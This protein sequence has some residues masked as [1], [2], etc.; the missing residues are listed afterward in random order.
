[1]AEARRFAVGD[2][3]VERRGQRRR[4]IRRTSAT[5]SASRSTGGAVAAAAAAAASL[6]DAVRG[7]LVGAAASGASPP[8]RSHVRRPRPPRSG[9]SA[10]RWS[11]ARRPAALARRRCRA[12]AGPRRPAP[13]RRLGAPRRR[14]VVVAAPVGDDEPADHEHGCRGSGRQCLHPAGAAPAAAIEGTTFGG[15]GGHRLR[16]SSSKADRAAAIA[17]SR[18]RRWRRRDRGDSVA[19]PAQP[20]DFGEQRRVALDAGA[21]VRRWPRRR[22]RRSP[23]QRRRGSSWSAIIGRF[24]RGSGTWTLVG[25]ATV[26]EAAGEQR[27]AAGDPRLHGADRDVEGGGDLGVVEIAQ[28]AQHD[29]DAELLGQLVERLVDRQPVDDGFD[30][31][32]RQGIGDVAAVP[33]SSARRAVPAAARACAVRR[34]RRWW[35][36]GRSTSRTPA[37]PSKRASPR[38]IEIIAS[39]AASSASRARAGDAPAD[40]VHTV[41]VAS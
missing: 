35:R 3:V 34:G 31:P 26:P 9:W 40:G 6:A 4:A 22:G 21:L 38:T 36:S 18:L 33:P 20:L 29:G 14:V 28:V 37:R 16:R 19:D 27:S 7:Q 39:W 25:R 17:A 41:V 23:A 15:A 12:S 11:S 30:A 13:W 24:V 5:R 8:Q 10:H 1:M 2:D 32:V